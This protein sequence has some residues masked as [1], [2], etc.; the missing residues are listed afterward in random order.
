M[1]EALSRRRAAARPGPSQNGTGAVGRR[2]GRAE[3]PILE[4]LGRVCL[5]WRCRAATYMR[6]VSSRRRAA[7]RP[8]TLP[9]GTGAVGRRWVRGPAALY[10]LL[11]LMCLR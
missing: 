8:I 9:N 4:T 10:V 6:G 3:A 11:V 7:A 2:W 1:R 5:R